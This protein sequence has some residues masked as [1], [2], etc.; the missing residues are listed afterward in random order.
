[1]LLG[2]E[3]LSIEFVEVLRATRSG[4]EPA[5]RR[6]NLQAANRRLVAGG[7][8]ELRGDG[9]TRQFRG[10]H[11]FGGQL[12]KSGLLLR[13]A[14]RVNPSVERAAQLAGQVMVMSPHVKARAGFD[15][16]RKQAE[17]QA[18]LLRHPSRAVA[19]QEARARAFLAAEAERAVMQAGR[20]VLEAHR[21]FAELAVQSGYDPV[22]QTAADNGLPDGGG[23]G[24][25]RPVPQQ[26][27]DSDGEVVVRVH[28]A[29]GGR[30]DAVA[31]GVRVAAERHIELVLLPLQAG[32]RV[33]AG[34]VHADLPVVVHRHEA[35]GRVHARVHDGEVQTVTFLDRLPVVYGRPAQR[36]HADLHV[37][38]ADGVH[39]QHRAE[40][41]DV[42]PDVVV[43]VGGR[44]AQGGFVGHPPQA[45]AVGM[46]ELI[47]AMLNPVGDIRVRRTAVRR[48]VFQPAV[49]RRV[50]GGRDANPIRQPVFAATVIL[51]DREGKSGRGR[52]SVIGL[53]ENLDAVGREDFQGGA[54]GGRGESMGVLRHEHRP[55]RAVGAPVVA[56]RLGDGEDVRLGEGAIKRR[57]AMP[58]GAE[59]DELIRVGEVRGAL[60]VVAFERGDINQQLRRGGLAS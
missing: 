46:Q 53:D 15:F 38:A 56:D 37:R 9:F 27:I 5:V 30:D 8:N 18:I 13:R 19:A 43:L 1:M 26:I 40:R 31:V 32:Q 10:L 16:R 47:R 7:I 44:G 28:Q 45:V 17:D 22:H 14:G 11:G 23:G 51:Q 59:A 34:A 24:P 57:A 21:H 33:G 50:V 36:V 4:S 12:L 48:I 20:E 3:A 41:F 6:H 55:R 35:E 2:I 52:E 60:V 29:H 49:G 39:V 42:G 25:I 58:A 54:L